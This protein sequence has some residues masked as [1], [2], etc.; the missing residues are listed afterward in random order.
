MLCFLWHFICRFLHPFAQL[1]GLKVLQMLRRV[2]EFQDYFFFLSGRFS[3]NSV[4]F[5]GS[6]A[7]PFFRFL[8]SLFVLLSLSWLLFLADIEPAGRAMA[9]ETTPVR[10]YGKNSNFVTLPVDGANQTLAF[11]D[12][13]SGR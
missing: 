8:F 2:K 7:L 12:E 10:W 4:T 11:E 13:P 3:V 5:E 9:P 1:K 6:F